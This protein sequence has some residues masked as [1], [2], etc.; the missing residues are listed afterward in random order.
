M[1]VVRT[2]HTEI[3]REGIRVNGTQRSGDVPALAS[4]LAQV[5]AGGVARHDR[6]V[7][8]SLRIERD[9]TE[10]LIIVV[11]VDVVYRVLGL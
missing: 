3:E 10:N 2:V 6:E 4:V 8:R 1:D 5:V 7:A 11:T 9:E